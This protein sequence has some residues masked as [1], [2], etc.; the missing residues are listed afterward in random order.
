MGAVDSA[1][2]GHHR[3]H[4][5]E[6]EVE[7]SVLNVSPLRAFPKS[8][9]SGI[10]DINNKLPEIQNKTLLCT[11][12]PISTASS[13]IRQKRRFTASRSRTGV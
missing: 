13:I 5:R 2:G 7:G 9:T 11:L 8:Q 4:A 1:T 3:T 12:A 6:T 10:R